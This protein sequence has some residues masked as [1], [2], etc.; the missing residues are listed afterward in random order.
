[1]AAISQAESPKMLV[2]YNHGHSTILIDEGS[3]LNAASDKFQRKHDLKII[4]SSRS[5]TAAGKHQL[6]IVGETLDDLIVDTKFG[7][8][9]FMINLGKVTIVRNLGCDLIMGEPGKVENG[10]ST[11]PV[12]R[13]IEINRHGEELS[14]DYFSPSP[15]TPS[16]CRISSS[17]ITIFPNDSITLDVPSRLRN[18]FITVTPRSDFVNYFETQCKYA[19]DSITL[20]NKNK[21]PLNLKK[22]SHIADIRGAHPTVLEPRHPRLNITMVDDR[23]EGDVNLVHSHSEDDYK[24]LPT[25]KKV[26]PPDTSK[27]TVDPDNIMP[28][29]VKQKFLEINK[30]FEAIF[31]PTAGRYNCHYGPVDNSLRFTSPPVQ[32]NKVYQ[33]AYSQDMK[34]QLELKIEELIDAGILVRPE[35]I[36]V[37]VEFVSPSLLVKKSDGTWRLVTD[38]TQLNRFIAPDASSNPSIQE[39]KFELSNKKFRAELD[40]SNYYYQSGLRREDAS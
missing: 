20:T 26:E 25:A 2:T 31:T 16:I 40:L 18:T 3:S 15:E 27:I 29:D 4:K 8:K 6:D 32:P 7:S 9:H 28:I 13:R 12:E 11:K 1:M 22:H 35:S 14:K 19:G 30:R 23:K 21:I 17:N 39:A 38:F 33:P 36:G 5:A 10:I 34:R 24:Y 37:T